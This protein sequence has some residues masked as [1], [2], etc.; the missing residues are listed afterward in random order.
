[1]LTVDV[2]SR[3][4]PATLRGNVDQAFVDKINSIT[5]DPALAETIRENFISYTGV[6]REGK[7]KTDDYL[8]AVV[9]VSHKMMGMSNQDAYCK[10]FP[11]R[12]TALLA[13]GATAKDI[14]AYA[15]MYNKGKLVNAVLEQTLIP[16]WVLNQDVYQKAINTQA[17]IMANSSNDMART[18]AAN[19][20][21]VHLAKPKDAAININLGMQ[22]NSG[23]DALKNTLRELAQQQQTLIQQGVSTKSI[24]E[25]RIIDVEPN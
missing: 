15:S 18:A 7:Y 1:M 9:Y 11:D 21:L 23:M 24:A 2:V 3:N 22:D 4:L 14:S 12:Y 16:M 20:I 10:T 13:K 8:A 5:N 17:D 19:S 6:L 25:S